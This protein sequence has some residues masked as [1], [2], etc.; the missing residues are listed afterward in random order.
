[1]ADN[2][3]VHIGENSPEHVAFKLLV[4]IADVEKKRLPGLSGGTG[5]VEPD[6]KWI[7]D[8]YVEC[9]KAVKSHIRP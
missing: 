4:V 9:S 6:R 2:A 7:L 3:V 5:F 1:M 8:T